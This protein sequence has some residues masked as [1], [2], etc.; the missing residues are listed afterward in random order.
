M[1]AVSEQSVAEFDA[2]IERGGVAIFPTDTLYGIG[3][4]PDDAQAVERIHQLKGRPP[5]QP[6][7]VLYF[8][9]DRLLDELGD[10]FDPATRNLVE[11]LFPGPYTLIVANPARRFAPACADTPERL[12]L[13]VPVLEH[14]LAPLAS[15]TSRVFQTSANLSGG[16]DVTDLEDVEPAILDGV[17]LALDGG[18]LLGYGSTVADVSELAHGRWRLLRAQMPRTSGR[19]QELIGFPPEAAEA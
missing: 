8:S 2:V 13:R 9:L 12:G 7:A 6:S 19:V 18:T 5:E 15:S 1:T 14:G 16:V 10:D 4:D 11:R 17:D 3:C